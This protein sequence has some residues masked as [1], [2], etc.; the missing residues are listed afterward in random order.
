MGEG[1]FARWACRHV[2]SGDAAQAHCV[3]WY[4]RARRRVAIESE[5]GEMLS[6]AFDTANGAMFAALK[7]PRIHWATYPAGAVTCDLTTD[8]WVDRT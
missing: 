4:A 7:C 8:A 2:S 3:A 6:D 5:K 1:D